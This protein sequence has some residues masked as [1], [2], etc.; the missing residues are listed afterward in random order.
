MQPIIKFD[1][2]NDAFKINHTLRRNK[3]VKKGWR[4]AGRK[5]ALFVHFLLKWQG[6]S[7]KVNLKEGQGT[8]YLCLHCG[9]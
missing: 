3:D 5:N 4:E 1:N 2:D 8:N 7:K 9:P 6:R